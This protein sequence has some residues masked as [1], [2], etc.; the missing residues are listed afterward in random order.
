MH[1]RDEALQD[2]IVAGIAAGKYLDPG[3]P[4]G[5]D[6]AGAQVG[7]KIRQR[8]RLRLHQLALETDFLRRFRN[9]P[10]VVASYL[11]T[12]ERAVLRSNA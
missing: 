7:R 11:G 6:P 8:Y 5:R 10:L 1:S 4:V 2:G 12:D 3:P 9:D